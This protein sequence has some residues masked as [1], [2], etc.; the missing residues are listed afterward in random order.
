M[1]ILGTMDGWH[2]D[3]FECYDDSGTCQ[4]CN[5]EAFYR[6]WDEYIDEDEE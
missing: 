4:D 6:A 5:D 3:E 2:G 1:T